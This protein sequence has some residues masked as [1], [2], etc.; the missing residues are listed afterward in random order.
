VSTSTLLV[1]GALG[2]IFLT[3]LS[4]I[5]WRNAIRVALVLVLAEGAI[6]KWIFPGASDLVYF[7]KDFVILGTYIGFYREYW[8]PLAAQIRNIPIGVIQICLGVILFGILNPNI[9]S[10]LAAALGIRGYLFYLPLVLVVPRIFRT[11]KEM[12]L[13]LSCYA[14]LAIPICVLGFLQFRSDAYSVLNTYASGISEYGASTFGTSE[15]IRITGTFSYL[16]GHTVF[17]NVFVA[18][19]I[20]LICAERT[21]FRM[22][23]ILVVSPLLVA[24]GFMSGSRASTL[25]MAFMGIGFV[26]FSGLSASARFRSSLGVLIFA[27]LVVGVGVRFFF[28]DAAGSSMAR[29]TGAGDTV[30]HRI[31]EQPIQQVTIA[32]EKGGIIGCGAGTTSPAVENLRTKLHISQPEIH[33]GYYDSEL[34]QI[35][36]EVGIVGFLAWYGFRVAVIIVLYRSY[37]STSDPTLKAL[38]LAAM[39]VHFPYLLMSLVLNH[40]AC[41]LIWAL[42]GLGVIPLLRPIA[43]PK[44]RTRAQATPSR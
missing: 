29:M 42:T 19:V 30:Y 14:L 26:L 18:L 2:A 3:A 8:V 44:S 23:L 27:G 21:P 34:G 41:V 36:A 1:F 15:R 17:V 4:S 35:L 43:E 11:Q 40:V 5:N 22:L 12:L 13:N 10:L 24:N 9:G 7:A 33:P 20:A 25:S 31:I 39:L 28:A 37:T 16:S 6:R 32:L 38:A